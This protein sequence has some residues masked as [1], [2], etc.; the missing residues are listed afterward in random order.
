MYTCH[1]WYFKDVGFRFEPHVFKK[2]HNVLMN[3]YELK[4]TTILSVRGVYFRCILWGIS[5][6]EAVSRLNNLVLENKRVL[7]NGTWCK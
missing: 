7:K 1:Y 4:N 5:K 3:A 6:D 2:C